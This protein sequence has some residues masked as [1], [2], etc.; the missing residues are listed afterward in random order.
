MPEARFLRGPEER[1]S[2][3]GEFEKVQDVV[4]VDPVR[5]R[6]AVDDLHWPAGDAGRRLPVLV[7]GGRGGRFGFAVVGA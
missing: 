2:V 1:H 5:G 7:G 6:L 4:H 3:V